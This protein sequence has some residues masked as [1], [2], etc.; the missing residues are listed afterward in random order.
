[1]TERE[2]I[3]GR[4]STNLE[5]VRGLVELYKGQSSRGQGRK[6][7]MVADLLRVAVVLLHATLEDLLRSLAEWKLPTAPALSLEKIPFTTLDKPSDKINLAE[8]ARFRGRSVDEVIA[9]SI[10]KH[11]ERSSFNNLPEIMDLLGRIE[12]K[13]NF[14]K[15]VKGNLAIMINRRHWIAHR[16]DRNWSSG[17]GHQSARTISRSIVE[18]WIGAVE[19][20]GALVLERV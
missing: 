7:V 5:R 8:L 1:M 17:A 13:V 9:D 11:L 2:E 10:E 12:I 20:F 3:E 18:R 15:D 6:A 14:P 16:A 19:T 4:F